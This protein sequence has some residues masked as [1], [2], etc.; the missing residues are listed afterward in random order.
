LDT[1]DEQ[2]IIYMIVGAIISAI[3]GEVVGVLIARHYAVKSS[4]ELRQ[5]VATLS[6]DNE[7]SRTLIRSVAR[8][9]DGL[10]SSIWIGTP[11]VVRPGSRS[12]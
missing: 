11:K 10:A 8:A 3:I 9:L 2:Q 6:A 5:V 12:V 7:T 4:A 1:I